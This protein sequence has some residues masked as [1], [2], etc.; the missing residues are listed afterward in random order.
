MGLGVLTHNYNPSYSGG[1]DKG[2][3]RFKVSL[4]KKLARPHL[5]QV[6]WYTWYIS[7]YT[8]SIGRR[9]KV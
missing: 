3:S 8:G 2:R 6:W 7:S 1:S 9:I 4:G 5:S